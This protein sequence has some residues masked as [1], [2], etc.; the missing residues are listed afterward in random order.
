MPGLGR[1]SK[2]IEFCW[3]LLSVLF[4]IWPASSDAASWTKLANLAP[5]GAGVMLQLPDGTIMIQ[6]STTASWMRLKPDASGSYINGPWA[7]DIA[8][9]PT[10]RLYFGSQV[11][12]NGKVWILG[13]EYSGPALIGNWSNT[14][15]IYDTV[16]NTWTPIAP[17]PNQTGCPSL[18][19]TTGNIA[20]GTNIITNLYNSGYAAGAAIAGTGIPPGTTV[21]SVDSTTQIHISNNATA[22]TTDLTLTFS[23]SFRSPGCFGDVPTMLLP[24]LKI[25]AGNIVT[26]ASYIYDLAADTWTPA[27]PKVFTD[28]SDEEGWV[29]LPD[30]SVFEY[31]IFKSVA[32]GSG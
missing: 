28:S 29:K 15:E 12:P 18:T 6:R 16:A 17:Y 2:G 20:N 11:L 24:G 22:T 4:V 3:G 13:G 32:A 9:A 19:Q 1:S 5:S 27:A 31:D 7:T 25:F 21:T 14:G 26:N 30:G 10:R 23:P 8:T